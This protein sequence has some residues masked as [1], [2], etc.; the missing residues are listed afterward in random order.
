MT[1]GLA[2]VFAQLA[3]QMLSITGSSDVLQW[4]LRAVYMIGAGFF[5]GQMVWYAKFFFG[6]P[7]RIEKELS[8]DGQPPRPSFRDETDE[9]DEDDEEDDDEEEEDE[10][11]DD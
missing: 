1:I 9:E 11:D 4:V 8:E 5:I 3:Y 7:G 6:M 10:D 2:Q